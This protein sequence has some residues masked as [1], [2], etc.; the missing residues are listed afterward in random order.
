MELS[1]KR[2]K[3]IAATNIAKTTWDILCDHHEGNST[4]K[5]SK[6]QMVQTQFENLKMEEDEDITHFNGRILEIVGDAYNLGEPI[7]KHRLVKRC[8]TI[9]AREIIDESNSYS[10]KQISQYLQT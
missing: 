5:Q 9:T 10:R 7:S 2:F 4:V 1:V 3:L 8:A 6:L